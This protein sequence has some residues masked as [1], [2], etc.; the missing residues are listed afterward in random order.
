MARAR[1]PVVVVVVAAW[2]VS[3]CCVVFE[4]CVWDG[5]TPGVRSCVRVWRLE[6]GARSVTPDVPA[7]TGHT[8]RKRTQPVTVLSESRPLTPETG[9]R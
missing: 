3:V 8:R 4:V 2:R 7:T 6:R 5:G 9:L 1:C